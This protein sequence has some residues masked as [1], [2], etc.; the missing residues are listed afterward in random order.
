MSNAQ[1]LENDRRLGGGAANRLLARR[2]G[3]WVARIVARLGRWFDGDC[4]AFSH[5]P[6]APLEMASVRVAQLAA[7]QSN[8]VPPLAAAMLGAAL[9]PLGMWHTPARAPLIAWALVLAAYTGISR[10]LR[11]SIATDDAGSTPDAVREFRRTTIRAI[12][13]GAIWACGLALAQTYADAV[14]RTLIATL[15]MSVMSGGALQLAVA[16]PMAYGFIAPVALGCLFAA[17]HAPPAAALPIVAAQLLNAGF[18][19]F[20]AHSQASQLARRTIARFA[21]EAAA[22]RDPLTGVGNRLALNERLAAAFEQR[23]GAGERF[24]L[25]CFDLDPFR[26]F[27]ETFGHAAGDEMIVRAA[28]VLR[29]ACRAD[30]FVARLGGD[31]F[32][33]VAS[34][35]P[36]RDAAA[37]LAQRIVAEFRRPFVFAWGESV[38]S[39]TVGVALAP[40]HGENGDRLARNADAALFRAKQHHSSIAFVDDAESREARERRETGAALRQALRNGEMRLDFQPLVDAANGATKGFEALLRWRRPGFAEAPA[41][42]FLVAAEECGCIE[43]IG[44]WALREAT[45]IAATWPNHLRVAVNVSAAQL[46][47]PSFMATIH[48]IVEA[49]G[50]DPRRLELEI[51]ESSFIDDFEAAAASLNALRRFGVAIALD[52]F[53]AGYSSM[54]AIARLP[55][56]RIK[57]DRGFVVDALANPRCAAVIRSAARLARELGLALT[58]EGVETREQFELLRSAGCDEMQG[59]LFMRPMPADALAAAFERCPPMPPMAE[60]GMR[61]RSAVAG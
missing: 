3:P 32:A 7:V 52:D 50:F 11:R 38:C 9:L 39:V 29:K 56:D 45:H 4:L 37:A 34:D 18:L 57:I 40:D 21:E 24:A 53:G 61:R 33:L 49:R 22:R 59:Y 47:S 41:S 25:M 13:K 6:L 15:S 36:S 46:K 55:L 28:L 26:L 8:G 31:A 5:R 23:A 30:D 54:T 1:R 27:N 35:M 14:Q 58:G 2:I 20:Q 10:A 16:L 17:V 60:A 48:E 51:T 42:L 19:V 12:V 44:V 43:E